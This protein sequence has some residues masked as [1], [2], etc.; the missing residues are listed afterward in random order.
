ML[1]FIT[2]L[3][4]GL[5]PV[6]FVTANPVWLGEVPPDADTKPPYITIFNPENNSQIK[7][8]ISINLKAG[9]GESKTAAGSAIESVSYKADWIDNTITL[10]N[11]SSKGQAP[12]VFFTTVLNLTDIPQGNHSIVIYAVEK[13]SYAG[14]G[15]LEVYTFTIQNSAIFSFS[16]NLQDS[17]TPS[18]PEFSLLAILPLLFSMLFIAAILRHRKTHLSKQTRRL[19]KKS[20]N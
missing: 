2:L 1:S 20:I 18:V 11:A 13:G 19:K 14:R 3:F 17:P 12:H 15:T 4:V 6:S 9:I 7:S 16:N 5:T 8:S 10:F